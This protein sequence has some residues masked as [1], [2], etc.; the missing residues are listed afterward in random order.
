MKN[1]ITKIES[2]WR[3]SNQKDMSIW[4]YA[5]RKDYFYDNKIDY[6]DI[7]NFARGIFNAI[8]FTTT[9]NIEDDFISPAWLSNFFADYKGILTFCIDRHVLSYANDLEQL[10]MAYMP[11]IKY[12]GYNIFMDKYEGKYTYDKERESRVLD[13]VNYVIPTLRKN[14]AGKLEIFLE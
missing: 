1:I 3:L 5:N 8:I 12:T 11:S 7:N 14:R 10:C 9:E 4:L 6:I 13:K 2:A